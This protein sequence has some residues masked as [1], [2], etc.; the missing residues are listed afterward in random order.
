M[1][2]PHHRS[3]QVWHALSRDHTVLPSIQTFLHE[4]NEPYLHLP[5]QLKLVLIY[6][7]RRDGRLSWH[8]ADDCVFARAWYRWERE[9]QSSTTTVICQLAA[10]STSSTE[11]SSCTTATSL[12]ASTTASNMAS[13]RPLT[14]AIY[15]LWFRKKLLS[16]LLQKR[17]NSDKIWYVVSWKICNTV[18]Y[19]F[20]ASSKLC[21]YTTVRSKNSC[22]M[23]MAMECCNFISFSWKVLNTTTQVP[24]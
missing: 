21:P 9:K 6:R 24:L 2:K 1:R 14:P 7:P 20:C 8:R 11:N 17:S 10:S 19:T 15:T 4:W 5:F 18:V 3:A 23:L 22:L 16:Y 12:H 13:V